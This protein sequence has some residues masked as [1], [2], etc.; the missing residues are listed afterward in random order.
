[1]DA[2]FT[3]M[4]FNFENLLGGGDLGATINEIMGQLGS[5]IFEQVGPPFRYFQLVPCS[6]PFH[7][8]EPPPMPTRS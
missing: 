3:T 6:I 4:A 1:M 2:N 8:M 7:P 5:S